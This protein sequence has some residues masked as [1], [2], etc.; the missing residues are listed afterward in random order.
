MARPPPEEGRG[1]ALLPF[2]HRDTRQL[3]G[4]RRLRGDPFEARTPA[5]LQSIERGAEFYLERR[6][7]REGPTLYR[8]WFRLHYPVHYYYDILVG[9]DTLTSLGYGE[10]PRMRPALDRL[11]AM[12]HRDGSWNM[13][14]LHPDTEDPAYQFRGPFYPLG[15]EVPGRP[16]RWITT[17]ALHVLKRASR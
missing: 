7:F 10:D 6:L 1:L 12:R 9:L 14:A 16:S 15:L 13:D 11:E 3:G 2:P 4:P 17:T 5:I 8:P